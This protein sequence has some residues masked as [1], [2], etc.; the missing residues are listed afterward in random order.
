MTDELPRAIRDDAASRMEHR[1]VS[2]LLR[3]CRTLLAEKDAEIA[4]LRAAL[5]K[6]MKASAR[7]RD[8]AA[9]KVNAKIEA[10][11]RAEAAEAR[12]GEAMKALEP[13]ADEA[14]GWDADR[15]DGH[16]FGDGDYID[17]EHRLKIG[18]LRAARRVRDGGKVDG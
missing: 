13:F 9:R 4:R 10:V 18:H 6:E 11:R 8:Y 3:D 15:N 1:S 17:F 12:L 2:D 16:V 5:T 7:Y 14:D